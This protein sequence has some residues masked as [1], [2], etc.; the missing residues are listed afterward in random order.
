MDA[1]I[2]YFTRRLHSAE[3]NCECEWT[4][5][6]VPISREHLNS[7]PAVI[8]STTPEMCREIDLEL[9]S[10]VAILL[11]FEDGRMKGW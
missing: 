7:T 10:R 2:L 4:Y 5:V 8:P 3:K 11:D 1:Q 9:L 6:A